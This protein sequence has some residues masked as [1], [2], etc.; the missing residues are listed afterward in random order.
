[1]S[2]DDAFPPPSGAATRTRRATRGP[3]VRSRHGDVAPEPLLSV[4]DAAEF[5]RVSAR[6]V[7]RLV[8]RG[9]LAASRVGRQ[10]RIV[11]AD[12]LAYLRRQLLPG[13]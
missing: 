13:P 6:T 5:L 8:A 10:V 1:M 3:A 2:P 11:P 7:R 9:E 12:L 4:A